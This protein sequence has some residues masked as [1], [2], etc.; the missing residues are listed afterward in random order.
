[1]SAP[2]VSILTTI[3]NREGFLEDCIRSVQKSHF[4]DYEHILVDDGSTD[5]SIEIAKKLAQEDE[6]IQFYSNNSNLGDYPNRNKAASLSKGQYIKYL[7]ADDKMGRWMLDIMVDAM[8]THPD[9]ALGLIDYADQTL[10]A[11]TALNPGE[12]FDVYYSRRMDIFNRSPLGA[13][14]RKDIFDSLGGFSGKRMIGDFEMWHLIARTHPVVAIPHALSFYRRHD[15]SETGTRH[16]DPIW[17]LYYTKTSIDQ[18]NHE[19]CPWE[20]KER[21]VSSMRLQRI[22][23]RSILLALKNHGPRK[24][25]EMR[26]MMGWSWLSTFRKA[27]SPMP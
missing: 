17:Q 15:D 16:S 26:A 27:F 2:K 14:I 11:A 19:A 20:Q 21:T 5:G 9:C 24:A 12:A 10:Y 1:M 23:A 22:A 25:Q 4:Q 13:I 18:L 8:E 6:R 7:D 3:F